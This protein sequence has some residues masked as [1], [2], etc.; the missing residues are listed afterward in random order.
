MKFR[1][2]RTR[3]PCR[4]QL[5]RVDGGAHRVLVKLDFHMRLF[6]SVTNIGW[7]T[8]GAISFPTQTLDG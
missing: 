1:Q 7:L 2:L 4:H 5:L 6:V 3:L 8:A